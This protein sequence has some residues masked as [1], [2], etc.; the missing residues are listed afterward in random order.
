VGIEA[1]GRHRGE[2]T[3]WLEGLRTTQLPEVAGNVEELGQD[4]NK[5]LPKVP[6]LVDGQGDR[7]VFMLQTEENV[8]QGVGHPPKE[9]IS[10]V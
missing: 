4:G 2:P 7:G 6:K 10:L 3:R 8:G 1:D 5:R 9:C